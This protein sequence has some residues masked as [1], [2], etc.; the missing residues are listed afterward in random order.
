MGVK[1]EI[2]NY[3]FSLG[4]DSVGFIKCRRFDEIK[5]FLEERK[6]S[7]LE[8][9]FEESN[10]ELRINSKEWFEEGKT[11]ISIAF[12]YVFLDENMKVKSQ[13]ESGF[14]IYTHGLDYHYVVNKYLNK[15]CEI[16]EEHGGK[17]KTFVDSNTL[18]ERYLAYIS[19]VGFIGKNNLIITKKHGSYVFLG[20]I[21]TDLEIYDEDKRTF[22]EIDLFKECGSCTVCYDK[23]P[24]KSINSAK[25]NCNICLSYITQK[26]DLN[27]W[28]IEKLGGRIFGCDTCQFSCPYNMK[29]ENSKLEDFKPQDFLNYPDED[30]IINMNN[31]QFKESFKR[32][33]CGWR[34]KN[35][36]KRNAL[37]RKYIYKDELQ[38]SLKSIKFDSPYLKEYSETISKIKCNEVLKK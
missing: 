37:I 35:V 23:C 8:N 25:K 34:G 15:I 11:I 33:S 13:D 7:N 27:E 3:C 20:E 19:G 28:E 36:L 21:I 4:I 12:P 38:D 2:I 30:Y 29:I 6:S 5:A 18:P 24:T 1:E 22:D 26:K 32:T 14:S 17:C 9:E 16:I 10:I 31:G